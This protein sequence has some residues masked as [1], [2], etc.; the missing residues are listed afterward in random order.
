MLIALE[1]HNSLVNLSTFYFPTKPQRFCLLSK[2]NIPSV[3]CSNWPMVPPFWGATERDVLLTYTQVTDSMHH[4]KWTT[5]AFILGNPLHR[6]W[7]IKITPQRHT[8]GGLLK[9]SSICID[10]LSLSIETRP[11][12][13]RDFHASNP[14]D[15]CNTHATHYSSMLTLRCSPF[16]RVPRGDGSVARIKLG[17]KIPY[18]VWATLLKKEMGVRGV[19]FPHVFCSWAPNLWTEGVHMLW[20]FYQST[21]V[22]HTPTL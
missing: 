5:Y 1:C 20:L 18:L 4:N 16:F 21:I 8:H 14:S 9:S 10:S 15:R 6:P 7:L 3:V 12:S 2:P 19:D 22:E 13:L 11:S 17:N